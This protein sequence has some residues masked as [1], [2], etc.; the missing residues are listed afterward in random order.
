MPLVSVCVL[1]CMMRIIPSEFSFQS[2]AMPDREN[3][4]LVLKQE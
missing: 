1:V 4:Y 3:P 2:G